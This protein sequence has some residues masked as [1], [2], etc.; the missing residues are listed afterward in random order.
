MLRTGV[1]CNPDLEDSMKL[2][3]YFFVAL[4]LFGCATTREGMERANTAFVGKNIDDFFLTYGVPYRKHQLTNGEFL[5][6]WNSGVISYG[7]PTTTN[8]TG[9][10]NPY[11]YSGTA[12]TYGGGSIDVFCEVQ[13]HTSAE[14]KILSI[15]P[16]SDTLGKWTTSRCAEIFK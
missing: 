1:D 9:T 5:Y 2:C 14:G 13:I 4:L 6:L 3:V 15:N 12:V 10:K 7:L 16:V 11:G 8:I